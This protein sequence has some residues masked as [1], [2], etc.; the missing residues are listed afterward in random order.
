MGKKVYQNEVR[1][2]QVF[3][4]ST[5]NIQKIPALPMNARILPKLAPH[6]LTF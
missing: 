6:F 1:V 4:S 2:I 3:L 5:T